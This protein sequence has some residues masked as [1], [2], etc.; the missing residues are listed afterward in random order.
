MSKFFKSSFQSFSKSYWLCLQKT[1]PMLPSIFHVH[2]YHSKSRHH[3]SLYFC[4]SNWTSS[5][6]FFPSL[7]YFSYNSYS[8]ILKNVSE[9][10]L[11]HPPCPALS[12]ELIINLD[13][14][15]WPTFVSW[16]LTLLLLL[17]FPSH[18]EQEAEFWRARILVST[19]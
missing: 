2:R 3:P 11:I 5:F 17:H 14:L 18:T 4:T 1:H 15:L 19:H 8:T 9:H 10:M 12:I 13:L 6:Y 7:I 16:H